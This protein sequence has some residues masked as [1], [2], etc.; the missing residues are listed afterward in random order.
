MHTYYFQTQTM[1]VGAIDFG[2]AYSGWAFSF[3]HEF[4]KEPTTVSTKIWRSGD[5]LSTEKTPTCALIASDGET[6][7]A[8]GYDAENKYRELA[9]QN[10]QEN[11]YYFKGFKMA[12]NKKLDQVLTIRYAVTASAIQAGDLG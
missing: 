3:K 10:E 5:N 1:I 9:E 11:Y 8:F 4:Q 6:L 7:V 12:L 2:T